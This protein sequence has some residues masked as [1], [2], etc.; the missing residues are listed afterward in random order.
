MTWDKSRK[1]SEYLELYE[2]YFKRVFAWFKKSFD[3]YTS[4]DLTQQTFLKLWLYVLSHGDVIIENPK[5]L[6]FRL[7]GNVKVDYLRA[8]SSR[9]IESLE[10]LE[11]IRN[12]FDLERKVEI[13][14]ALNSLTADERTV[15]HMKRAGFGSKETAEVLGVTPS[16]ARTR[17]QLAKKKLEGLLKP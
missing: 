8:V 2:E 3:T 15:L 14:C 7:A 10:Y 16:G 11:E 4:E 5:A 1:E 13:I 9:P 12:D 6:V 17:L